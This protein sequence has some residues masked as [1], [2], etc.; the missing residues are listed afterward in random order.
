[1]TRS[2]MRCS[3]SRRARATK[4]EMIASSGTIESRVENESAE[5]RRRKL[6]RRGSS[7][8][9]G[10]GNG[11]WPA[12]R[13]RGFTSRRRFP[14][15][16]GRA[17]EPLFGERAA[18]ALR[19]GSSPWLRK[20][21]FGG[22][23]AGPC[24]SARARRGRRAPT[25]RASC[26]ISARTWIRRPWIDTVW[27]RRATPGRACRKLDSRRRGRWIARSDRRLRQVVDD[28]PAGRHAARGDDHRRAP[29]GRSAPWTPR[30]CGSARSGCRRAGP[31]RG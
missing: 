13:E 30:P 28:A 1:M 31:C 16:V 8:R 6:V 9:R 7:G 21:R 23:R 22:D 2:M 26:A 10:R 11:R 5:A 18:S 27:R 15:G 12:S 29:A 4:S 24:T 14:T 25:D 17:G 3:S 20:M 19:A